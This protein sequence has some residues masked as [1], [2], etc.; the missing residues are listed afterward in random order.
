MSPQIKNV[1]SEVGS[2]SY[3]Q[4]KPLKVTD[5]AYFQ[6]KIDDF[7]MLLTVFHIMSL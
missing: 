4:F 1:I 6:N 7:I 3:F 2:V 5:Y